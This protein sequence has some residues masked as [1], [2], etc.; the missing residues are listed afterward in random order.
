MGS[1][2]AFYAEDY[3]DADQ[4]AIFDKVY[5][6]KELTHEE[7]LKFK[8]A[9]LY[10]FAVQDY[11]GTVCCRTTVPSATTRMFRQLGP[12]TGFDYR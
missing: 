10:V 12:D 7:M 1:V 5:A 2:P 3:T 11:N 8:S 9:M 4:R 6:G